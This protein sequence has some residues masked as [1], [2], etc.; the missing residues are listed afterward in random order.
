VSFFLQLFAK[1]MALTSTYHGFSSNEDIPEIHSKSDNM[2]QEQG[3][4]NAT[5]MA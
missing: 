5:I 1:M 4:P 3:L 2:Y